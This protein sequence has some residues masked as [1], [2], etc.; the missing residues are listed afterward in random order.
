MAKNEKVGMSTLKLKG[1]VLRWLAAFA[2]TQIENGKL[3][4]GALS[5]NEALTKCQAAIG[6]DV[7]LSPAKFRGLATMMDVKFD[8]RKSGQGNKSPVVA[9]LFNRVAELEKQNNEL[10]LLANKHYSQI[11][12]LQTRLGQV[13]EQLR[14]VHSIIDSTN[15][16][17]GTHRERLDAVTNRLDDLG[18]QI[19][20]LFS[21]FD[22][23]AP[24]Q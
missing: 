3:R 8:V 16:A 6:E 10:I 1:L 19:S 17:I 13:G 18:H 24:V 23:V 22:Q 2:P 4:E 20:I 14:G 15:V 11:A 9:Q 7:P 12:E 21:R 5:F